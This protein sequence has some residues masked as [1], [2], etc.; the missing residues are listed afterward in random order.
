MIALSPSGTETD[1]VLIRILI[2]AIG[3]AVTVLLAW[4]VGQRLS[5]KWAERQKSR[6]LAI[7]A[8]NEFYR[9]YGE[10][11]AIWKLWNSLRKSDSLRKSGLGDD[12]NRLQLLERATKAE[13]SMEALLVKLSTERHLGV[14]DIRNIG[15]F[16]QLFQLL[17]PAIR[18]GVSLGW[19]NS[20]HPQ[21]VAFKERA[22]AMASIIASADRSSLPDPKTASIAL[23]EMT[24][25]RWEEFVAPR[26]LP[27]N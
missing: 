3:P 25:N 17:R 1:P 9:I 20:D 23:L 7:L 19:N 22:C 16:R 14:H 11:F 15:E 26:V 13:G 18:T 6:E 2:A 4:L 27:L 12:S 24:S 10:F 21:Y 8:A 5:A